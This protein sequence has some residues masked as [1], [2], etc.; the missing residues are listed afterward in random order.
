MKIAVGLC[1]IIAGVGGLLTVFAVFPAVAGT[2][3][4]LTF[5]ELNWFI[6]KVEINI[7]RPKLFS[8]GLLLIGVGLIGKGVLGLIA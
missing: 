6:R 4:F 3:T 5:R 7:A 2:P 1:Q 8:A